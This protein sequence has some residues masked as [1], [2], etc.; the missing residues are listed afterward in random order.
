[1]T[2]K[3]S[4]QTLE[5]KII[6]AELNRHNVELEEIEKIKKRVKRTR[7][8]IFNRITGFHRRNLLSRMGSNG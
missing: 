8:T 3:C 5:D 6:R 1:M 2:L 4:I 7:N